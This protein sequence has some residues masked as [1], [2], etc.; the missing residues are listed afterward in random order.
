MAWER[1]IGKRWLS[2]GI[3]KNGIGLGFSISK[4]SISVDL[5]FFY[6]GLEL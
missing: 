6:I 2:I 1:K 3:H 5:L 4:Y